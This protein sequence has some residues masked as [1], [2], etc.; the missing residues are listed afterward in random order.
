MIVLL[1]VFCYS[2]IGDYKA[3]KLMDK[4]EQL[5]VADPDSSQAILDEVE[6]LIYQNKDFARWCLLSGKV[7]DEFRK[8]RKPE[9]LLSTERWLRAQT[10]YDK[11]GTLEEKAN[12][13][14]Y[15]GR[16][17]FDNGRYDDAA[18][19]YK[20]GLVFAQKAD[21]KSLSG[22]LCSYLGDLY[23]NKNMISMAAEKYRE[24]VTLH[25]QAGNLRSQIFALLD[26]G[27]CYIYDESYDEALLIFE[28][29]DTLSNKIDDN[30][31]KS[32]IANSFGIIYEEMEDYDAAEKFYLRSLEIDTLDQGTVYYNLSMVF[33]KKGNIEK[34]RDYLNESMS[35]VSMDA[36]FHQ[37][38]LIGKAEGNTDS[39]LFYLEQYKESLDSVL[40][41][42]NKINIYEVEQKYDKTQAINEK[43]Q[44]RVR[45][46]RFV[47][48][49]LVLVFIIVIGFLFYRHK[50][51][52][53]LHEK[54]VAIFQKDNEYRVLSTRLNEKNRLLS[55]KEKQSHDFLQQK[56]ALE[57]ARQSLFEGKIELLKQSPTG[58]KIVKLSAKGPTVKSTPLSEKDWKNLDGLVKSLF[59]VL[60][61][62]LAETT[63]RSSSET[64][65]LC[66]LAFFELK[67]KD[68]AFLLKKGDEAIRQNHVRIRSLFDIKSPQNLYSYCQDYHELVIE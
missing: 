8:V 30:V 20:D 5:L 35:N 19:V 14:L 61:D 46:L 1:L 39:A 42:Q 64:F 37:Q 7:E 6:F 16:S 50:T 38:Y 21:A 11:Y 56:Q 45:F 25:Q 68:E 44:L 67:A 29:V 32:L 36:I 2:C 3:N 63:S 60:Y 52:K 27:F 34:A 28:E 10:Y 22:Y 40:K 47:V 48:A 15:L 57:D 41:E 55:E 31:V 54:Q 62:H 18:K 66:L 24:A 17:L 53:Q 12:I 23:L 9:A 33:T 58:Q 13:R 49:G 65:R 4:A 43:N 51:N 26:L 59:P